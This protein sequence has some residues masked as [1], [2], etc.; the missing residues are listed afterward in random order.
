[1]TPGTAFRVLGLAP[2]A[3]ADD[4]RRAWLDLAQV[5]HPDRFAHDDRLRAKAERNLQRINAAYQLLAGG[6]SARRPSVAARLTESFAA[7]LGLGELGEA[8]AA[9]TGT[10]APPPPPRS[11]RLPDGPIGARH[12]VRVL[13]VGVPGHPPVRRHRARRRR[14]VVLSVAALAALALL[15]LLR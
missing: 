11:A 6:A 8:P 12:S 9:W 13:G 2:G 15:L 3:S 5:W 14:L 1:M 7:I 4:L 10:L